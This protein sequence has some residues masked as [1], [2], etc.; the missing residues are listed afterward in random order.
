MIEATWYKI[1]RNDAEKWGVRIRCQ[2]VVGDECEVTNKKGET[3]IVYL[4]S[5]AAKFDDAELWYVSD[6]PPAV[7][8]LGPNRAEY[9]SVD[10]MF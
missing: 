6:T 2:G 10:E 5:R 9:P 7:E 1:K 3:K 4:D 8:P